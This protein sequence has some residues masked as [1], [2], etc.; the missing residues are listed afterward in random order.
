MVVAELVAEEFFEVGGGDDAFADDFPGVIAE[1]YDGGDHVG[2][3]VAGVENERDA[4]AEL[5]HDL[6]A[7]NAGRMSG[8]IGAGS[9]DGAGELVDQAGDDS[10]ARPA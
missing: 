3:E 4:G 1:D 9:G 5:L 8:N 2:A 7:G 6:R 10:V